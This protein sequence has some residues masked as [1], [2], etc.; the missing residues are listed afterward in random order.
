MNRVATAN[1]YSTVLANLMQAQ[2]RQQDANAQVSSQK[3]ASDLKGYARQAET[4]LATRSIQAKVEGYLAQGDVLTSRLEAQNL[5]LTQIAD[6]A[7]SARQAIAEALASGRG[8]AL[9][10]EIS[11]WFSSAA[12]SLNAKYGG[13]YLFSGGQVDTPATT[14]TKITDLTA[15][16][17]V[18]AMFQN[19]GLT[20]VSQLDE[21]TTIETGFLASDIGTS[22]F[23][24]F[25]QMQAWV[26]ANGDFTGK[27]TPAQ[28]TFLQGML[29]DF[30]TARS[31]A[32]DYAARNGLIQN[33]VDK[34][35]SNQEDR[36]TM[37][38]GMVGSI[39]DADMPLAITR[40]EQ[41][42][43]AVQASAQVFNMLSQSSLLGLLK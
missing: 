16:P 30:D 23:S 39:T 40:L 36:K 27:L 6:S 34:I 26:E 43:V 35:L 33:R 4:L 14:A 38:E 19:D 10:G 31:T 20:P 9:M 37:L 29:D 17:P 5:A 7:Q 3:N 8:E 15:G 18:T 24:A 1:S 13:R 42:Q 25:Q 11:A 28:E 32:T 41:A 12:D 2:V 22:V 21:S